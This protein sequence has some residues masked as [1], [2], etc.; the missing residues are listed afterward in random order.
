LSFG[1]SV[2]SPRLI[3]PGFVSFVGRSLRSSGKKEISDRP[4]LVAETRGGK[5][6]GQV[7]AGERGAAF[8][9]CHGCRGGKAS[10]ARRTHGRP[11]HRRR[12]VRAAGPTRLTASIR[13]TEPSNSDVLGSVEWI[14]SNNPRAAARALSFGWRRGSGSYGFRWR[15]SRLDIGLAVSRRSPRSAEVSWFRSGGDPTGAPD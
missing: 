2:R 1:A 3:R 9:R 12:R 15:A 11:C 8:V 6:V 13:W 14:R 10:S 5:R 7:V 4:D